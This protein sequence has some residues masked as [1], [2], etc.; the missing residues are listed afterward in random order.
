MNDAMTDATVGALRQWKR[1]ASERRKIAKNDPI[2]ETLDYC[3][4]DLEQRLRMAEATEQW[5]TVEAFAAQPDVGVSPQTV[6]A[7][8]RAG[9]LAAV[10]GRN[11]Y[12]I[13]RGEKRVTVSRASA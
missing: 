2:A 8:I 3:A 12:H 1:E 13:R 4:A 5:I 11:G 6:R 10:R 9:E 7:W